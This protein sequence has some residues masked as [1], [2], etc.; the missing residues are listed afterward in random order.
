MT[1]FQA[2]LLLM[3]AACAAMALLLRR[4]GALS[5]IGMAAAL[6]VNAAITGFLYWAQ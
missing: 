1:D 2:A 5:P 6:A 4:Q 3:S